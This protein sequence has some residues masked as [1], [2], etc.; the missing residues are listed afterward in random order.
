[1][2]GTAVR[3]VAGVILLALGAGIGPGTARGEPGGLDVRAP[4][5]GVPEVGLQPSMPR[6]QRGI[7]EQEFY[8][9]LVRS[10]HE[11]AFFAPLVATVRMASGVVLRWGLS[12]WTAPAVPFDTREATGGVAVGLTVVWEE[13]AGPGEGPPPPSTGER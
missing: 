2:R 11:P 12:A 10:R 9:G 7:R 6:D 13:D 4:A 3:S 1:M 8:P 5:P